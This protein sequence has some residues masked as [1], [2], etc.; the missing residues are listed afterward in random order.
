MALLLETT[1][2]DLVIDLDI[3]GSPD[4]CKNILKLAK[5]RYYTSTLVYNVHPNRFCQLGD[6]SG[7]GTGGT[8]IYGL[9]ACENNS[10]KVLQS[11]RRFL[12]SSGGRQ[13][14]TAECR[15]KGRVV[16]TEMN[17]IPDTIG[18]Q[19]LITVNEGP[20]NALDGFSS[21]AIT[22]PTDKGENSKQTFRSIGVVRE[23]DNNILDKIA[24]TYCDADGRPY[25]DIRVIR[26]LIVDDPFEDPPGM[27]ELLK[28][29]GVVVGVD[30][31]MVM[32]SPEYERPTEEKVETRIQADQIDPVDGEEDQ[33]KLRQQEEESQ[34]REDKS[35]ARV[36]E[37]LG[38]LPDA[39]IKAP[40]DVLF[41]CKLNPITE[42]EDLEL[43]FSRFDE[44]VK[45]EIIRD[46]ETGSS[47]Q[48]AFVEFSSKAQAV[49]AYFK[50]NNTLVDDR[51]I[52]V[53]FSQSVAKIW[54]RF[55]QRLRQPKGRHSMP[56]LPGG[57]PH[58][59][60]RGPGRGGRG[61]GGRFGRDGGR[62]G[63]GRGGRNGRDRPPE[64]HHDNRNV[65]APTSDR[66]NFR[67]REYDEFGREIQ[68][69]HSSA[70]SR[71]G[72]RDGREGAQEAPDYHHGRRDREVGSIH[73]HDRSHSRSR[74][75]S[76]R[77]HRSRSGSRDRSERKHKKHHRRSKHSHRHKDDRK[78][79][80]RHHRRRDS[81]YDSGS[82]SDRGE[83]QRRD[84]HGSQHENED[85]SSDRRAS[86]KHRRH[87][88]RSRRSRSRS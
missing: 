31:G 70:P 1:L 22:D 5:A 54:D 46:P 30:D 56:R 37:M 52:K 20:G 18:S 11:N 75:R 35:R 83:S 43:I 38:D 44:K 40:E 10:R 63:R 47:L 26:A 32:A 7:D 25:A 19:F 76:P 3:D 85:S 27:D 13:L 64:M 12:K 78:E 48:Y 42:D 50:M 66:N 41:V 45:V 21:L 33:E 87:R 2:G 39:E 69:K 9:I 57:D 65:R 67:R 61:S 58:R 8:C 24:G 88:K 82:D 81:S 53:D 15:E 6:P 28:Q 14:T 59:G 55:N 36:L 23:D 62:G 29:R 34:Q 17:G 72:R 73:R 71:D 60:G 79:R 77:R 16:A 51:R 74:S 4:L 49:E 84:R 86:R 68:Y 80:K